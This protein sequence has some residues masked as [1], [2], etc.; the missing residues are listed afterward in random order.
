MKKIVCAVILTIMFV[1]PGVSY[2]KT[3]SPDDCFRDYLSALKLNKEKTVEKYTYGSSKEDIEEQKRDYAKFLKNQ[4]MPN[5]DILREL[6][7]ME[8]IAQN[9]QSQTRLQSDAVWASLGKIELKNE[10]IEG[11]NAHLSYIAAATGLCQSMFNDDKVFLEVD[12]KKSG[13]IWKV[14]SIRG[15]PLTNYIEMKKQELEQKKEEVK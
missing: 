12:M 10:T 15:M 5:E 1:L 3:K 13:N 8:E 9:A 11:T 6:K 2:A 4:G 7:K 14:S